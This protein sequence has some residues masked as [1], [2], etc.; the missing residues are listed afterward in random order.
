LPQTDRTNGNAAAGRRARAATKLRERLILVAEA[1]RELKATLTVVVGWA[2][3]LDT[4]W[5]TLPSE[6][7]RH[8]VA[9]IGRR[10]SAMVE[11]CEELIATLRVAAVPLTRPRRA[12]LRHML[13]DA[14]AGF[15]GGSAQHRIRT[16]VQG[17]PVAWVDHDAFDAVLV[18]LID[19]AL[20]YAP[21]GSD[22]ILRA[23]SSGHCA[24][25]EVVDAG[26]GIP[27]GVDLFAPFTQADPIGPMVTECGV[28]LY[29]V[30]CLAE[31]MGGSVAA[32][33]NHDS[34]STF[35]VRLPLYDGFVTNGNGGTS[36]QS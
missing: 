5:D 27:V 11:Q 16:Q 15:G 18:H 35:T 29:I 26:V 14:A 2:S 21:D 33:R 1:E 17:N 20:R 7:R 30:A 4:D 31:S 13:P 25:I 34:G 32:H 22:V 28:G 23:S 24:V 3:L 36:R 12:V 6:Q 9:T 10:A 19:N 8:G